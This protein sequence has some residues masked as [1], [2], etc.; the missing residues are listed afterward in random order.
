MNLLVVESPVK[1]KTIASFLDGDWKALSTRGHFRDLPGKDSIGVYRSGDTILFDFQALPVKSRYMDQI[2][3]EAGAASRICIATDPDREGEAIAWHVSRMLASRSCERI[4]FNAVVKSSVRRAIE[5]PRRIDTGLV[6]AYLARRAIDRVI[7]YRLSP[8]ATAQLRIHEADPPYSVGRVQ[9]GALA[10]AGKITATIQA[11]VE[12]FAVRALYRNGIEAT[13]TVRF[14]DR[15]AARKTMLRLSANAYHYIKNAKI[16]ERAS[17]APPPYTTATLIKS[18]CRLLGWEAEK[19]MAVAQ[20]LYETGRITYPRTDSVLVS[21]EGVELARNYISSAFGPEFISDNTFASSVFAQDA[22]ECIRPTELPSIPHEDDECRL[23][24]EIVRTRFVA[25]QMAHARFRDHDYEIIGSGLPLEAGATRLLFPGHLRAVAGPA[26]MARLDTGEIIDRPRVVILKK[27]LVRKLQADEAELFDEAALVEAMEKLGIGRP[28]TYA[29]T[30][31]TLFKRG[32]CRKKFQ[33]KKETME[34]TE[35]GERLLEWLGRTYPFISDPNFTG[36]IERDLDSIAKG[37]IQRDE[38]IRRV[39]DRIERAVA[40]NAPALPPIDPFLM[41][42]Q[43]E[44]SVGPNKP[45]P[46]ASN[47]KT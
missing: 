4:S 41:K 9:C 36:E 26:E 39:W 21:P 34:V 46:V 30:L 27:A 8:M 18:C 42:N 43:A 6:D 29:S 15:E 45:D 44:G 28:S 20:R 47:F 19:C 3:K 5:H 12:R 37:K 38:L 32:Y 35:R 25:C 23:L 40:G 11:R 2:R 1:A 16:S 10:V 24:H 33:E 14:R 22:H 13:H 17:C 7:G 31:S